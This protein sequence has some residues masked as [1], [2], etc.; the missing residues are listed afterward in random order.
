MSIRLAASVL[1]ELGFNI[2]P[3]DENKKPIGPWNADKRL[4]WEELEKRLAKASGVAITGR[5]LEDNDYGIMILD[6]DDVD[7][8]NETLSRVFGDWRAK[9]CGRGWSFCGF[10]GPRPKGKVKCDCKVPGEDCECVIEGANE[11]K[12]LSELRRGMYIVVRVPKNCLPGGTTRSDAIEVMATNYEVV[13]GRHPSGAFYQPMKYV[14]GRWVAIDIEDVRQGEVITC[15]E[16]RT[17]IA[18]IKQPNTQAGGDNEAR[19]VG[20]NLP[21][22]TRE[23]GE[24]AI[25]KIIGLV[26]PIWWLETSEGKHIHDSLLYGLVSQMRLAGVRYEDA[27]KVVG[28]IINA[29]IQDIANNV[30]QATLQR[31]VREEERH[32]SE[33]VDYLYTKPTAK[34]WGRETFEEAVKPVVQKAIEQG[35]LSGVSSHEEWFEELYTAIF[36]REPCKEPTTVTTEEATEKVLD[37]YLPREEGPI[38]VPQWAR[39]L[40]VPR[41]E[42]C[43]GKPICS[44]S[45]VTYTREDSQYVVITIKSEVKVRD[46]E[47]NV[48]YIPNYSPIALLPR[49]MA[50]VYDPFYSD[51]FFIALHDGKV[52]AASTNFDEFIKDLRSAPGGRYYII[53]NE[54]YLDL[55][56]AILPNAKVVVSAGTVDDGF[57]DPKNILD[58]ADYGVEPLLK[59]YE[60][61][62]KYYPE[63]NARWAWFN[64]MAG[65]A[66]VITPSVRYHNRTFNDMVVYNVGRGGEGKTTLVRYI[67]SQLLGGED[68]GEEYYV[69]INGSLKSDA[70]LRNLLNLNRLPLILDEQ[71]KDALKKN[72]GIFLSAV[73]GFGTIGVHAAK[74]GLGIATKFKNLRGMLVFTNV[75][76]VSFLR[77]VM[78]ETSDYAIIRRFIEIAWDSEPINPAAFKDLPELKPIYGFVARLWTK[79]RD[80]L[81]K[82]ADLLELIEKLAVAI[83][84]EYL[85]DPKVDEMVQYTLSIVREVR[86]A[87]RNERLALNDADTL[88]ANAYG[89]VSN[90]IK[91]PPTSAIKVLRVILENP[92]RAGLLLAGIKDDEKARKLANDLNNVI[93]ELATKYS[94][95][96]EQ[97]RIQGTDPDTI[98]VYSILKDALAKGKYQIVVLARSALIPGSPGTFMGSPRTNVSVGGVRLK[99]YYLSLADFVRLFLHRENIVTGEFTEKS[100]ENE[101]SPL[102]KQ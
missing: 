79:Y 25:N 47:G 50:Q 30:D 34:P 70:Q 82:A 20:F 12:K 43:L 87:K 27:R 93:Q 5:Y 6:L 23:L 78:S 91:T 29:G 73:I 54:Q 83:G 38:N 40:E 64:V 31:I 99:G 102:G 71:N 59:A 3:V 55:I 100:S 90:E 57:V 53:K 9:L 62:R 81:V 15:D 95:T 67:L 63:G 17:L 1:Y 85:G 8:A 28:G 48:D 92:S 44:K 4:P 22:P 41:L 39:G 58:V 26:R 84:R 7:K 66:K 86:E 74:Y 60:W 72:I 98:V 76:F 49:F 52:I 24:D 88:I 16:L 14:D 75:L 37:E 56:K 89:F 46:P 2:V 94:I 65:F 68:A 45:L 35:L 11:K 18:L 96:E 32:F 80:E 33:T 10:T 19:A 61:I 36:G 97:G 21:E 69:V 51:W 101:N 42:Y 13:F 77:D